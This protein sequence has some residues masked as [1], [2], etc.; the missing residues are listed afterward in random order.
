MKNTTRLVLALTLALPLAGCGENK[1]ASN[2]MKEG[3]DKVSA[4]AESMK[5][6]IKKLTDPAVAEASKAIEDLEKKAST[7]T[8]EAK[9]KMDSTIK[10]I[11][12]KKD[13]IVKMANEQGEDVKAKITKGIDELK[14]MIHDATAPK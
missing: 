1:A 11:A 8:G 14:K 6:E 5:A 2:A 12:A 13:E 7:M 4:T 10:S 9:T 3:A